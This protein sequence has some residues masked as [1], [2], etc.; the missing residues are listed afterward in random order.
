MTL[1]KKSQALSLLAA[2]K[3][4]NEIA[5]ELDVSAPSIYKWKKESE[6]SV[7]SVSTART[8]K[9]DNSIEV[10]LLRAELEFSKRQLEIYKRALVMRENAQ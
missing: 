8:V 6:G 2:G 10:E 3:S 5:K 7:S 4:V 1:D 9:L